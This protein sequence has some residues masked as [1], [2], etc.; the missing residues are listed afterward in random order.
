MSTSEQEAVK[1]WVEEHGSDYDS[2]WARL[3]TEDELD[4]WTEEIEKWVDDL[5]FD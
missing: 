2:I 1:Q 4:K 5:P 3:A